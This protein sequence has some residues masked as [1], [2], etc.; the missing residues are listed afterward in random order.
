MTGKDI[1]NLIKKH[2]LYQWEVA[3]E[4][5]INESTLS[6]WLRGSFTQ[7]HETTILNAIKSLSQ[8]EW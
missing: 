3:E 1:K 7:E 4:L 5:G 6:R 8:K 2:R